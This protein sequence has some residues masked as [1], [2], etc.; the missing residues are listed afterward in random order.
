MR[1]DWDEEKN[2]SN[3]RKHGIGFEEAQ[4]V[5]DDPLAVS[6]ADREHSIAEERWL[7]TGV[8]SEGRLLVVA[9]TYLVLNGEE[10]IRIISARR[11]TTHERRSYEEG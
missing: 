8:S 11:P 4:T 1:F 2:Q 6:I 3:R 7:T 5:F 9:H 10:L